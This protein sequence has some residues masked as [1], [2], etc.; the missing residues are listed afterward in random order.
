M[1]N[2]KATADADPCGM[3]NEKSKGRCRSLRDDKRKKARADADPCR[4]D[5]QKR[6]GQMRIPTG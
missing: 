1:T 6:Q 2:E 5:N 4:D 3:T